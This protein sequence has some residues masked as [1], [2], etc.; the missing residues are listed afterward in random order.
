MILRKII[1]GGQ[2]GVDSGALYAALKLKIPIGGF[3]PK[4]RIN[5]KGT[6]PEQFILQELKTQSYDERTERNV[7]LA[8]ATLIICMNKILHGGTLLTE[9]LC[10]KHKKPLLITQLNITD[11]SLIINWLID[12]QITSLNVAGPRESDEPGIEKASELWLQE[13]FNE[14]I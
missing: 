5:E 11:N 10:Q 9:I 14:L 8:E 12:N 6:I 2:T 4:G 1:S 3:C 7:L 13:I